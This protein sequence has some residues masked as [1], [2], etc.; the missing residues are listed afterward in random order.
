MPNVLCPH[1]RTSLEYEL[2]EF[3]PG[4]QLACPT[5]GGGFVLPG[6]M[7]PMQQ[8]VAYKPVLI[9][10]TAKRYKAMQLLGGLMMLGSLVVMV[11]S[12]VSMDKNGPG[13]QAAIG[14]L[15]GLVGAVI[16]VFGRFFAW[17]RHG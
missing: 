5:C 9:E 4:E 11:P 12:C 1:C 10:Q 2:F 16:Y 3:S 7:A 8:P 14:V 17:W 6:Q 15:V 13:K